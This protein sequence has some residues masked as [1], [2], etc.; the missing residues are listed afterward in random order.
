VL[1]CD[2]ASNRVPRSLANLGLTPGQLAR[3]IAWDPG[4][5]EVARGLGAR[6]DAPLVLAGWSRLVI[7]LNR[8]LASPQSIPEESDGVLV[9]GNLGLTPP[10]RA[11]RIATLF[12]PYHRAVAHLLE[13]RAARPTLL[14]SIH[15]FTAELGGETRPW[16]AGVACG[17]DR[18][19]AEPLIRALERHGDLCIGDNE[20]YEVDHRHDYTLPTHGEGRGI[21]HAMI[22]IRQDQ[23][24]SVAGSDAWVERLADAFAYLATERIGLAAGLQRLTP[25]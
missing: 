11:C 19:L 21:P 23:L 22:E 6:L 18:R 24:D 2:H 8:P 4:A 5:A 25:A 16:H 9:P 20:P 10:A 7:D 17:S 1:V 15:S 14:V 12:D 3:H 13:A